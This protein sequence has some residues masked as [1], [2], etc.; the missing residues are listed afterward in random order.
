V[1]HFSFS[2]LSNS[3]QYQF[4]S[5]RKYR[6]E[7]INYT[8]WSHHLNWYT[9]VDHFW[10]IVFTDKQTNKLTPPHN[11]SSLSEVIRLCKS[12]DSGWPTRTAPQTSCR[13]CGRHDMPPPRPAT[14]ARCGSLEPG[15]LS[16]AR[17]ANTRHP[18]GRPHTPPAERMYATDVSDRQTSVSII[19]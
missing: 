8:S 18:A 4:C 9:S 14:E 16:R 15:R 11:L 2:S 12:W 7:W 13:M 19:A 5:E 17:S 3:C 1:N 6:A 10:V